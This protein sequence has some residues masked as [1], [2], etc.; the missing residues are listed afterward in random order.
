MR[1][2]AKALLSGLAMAILPGCSAPEKSTEKIDDPRHN[3]YF[4]VV[5]LLGASEISGDAKRALLAVLARH[6]DPAVIPALIAHLDDPCPCDD[7][8]EATNG[9]RPDMYWTS[10][11]SLKCHGFLTGLLR[12]RDG[13][14]LSKDTA[15]W[16]A[17]W[18]THR[19]LSLEEM[20]DEFK[21]DKP[22]D[23]KN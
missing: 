17:W 6:D 5:D 13:A 8:T 2:T 9:D 22:S 15:W 19:D 16:K 7:K 12:I 20:R 10:P 1:A 23:F 18:A 4:A 3:P 11:V 14:I 21:V